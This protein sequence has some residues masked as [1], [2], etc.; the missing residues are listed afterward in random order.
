MEEKPE[1][2]ASIRTTE[3]VKVVQILKNGNFALFYAKGFEVFSVFEETKSIKSIL[4][5]QYEI[6]NPNLR[7]F[8]I[9]QPFENMLNIFFEEIT[10]KKE[11]FTL[12]NIEVEFLAKDVRMSKI[13]KVYELPYELRKAVTLENYSK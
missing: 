7:L 9:P 2:V 3:E 11:I 4:K 1:V 10:D 12:W 5:K 8:Q 13:S 6:K